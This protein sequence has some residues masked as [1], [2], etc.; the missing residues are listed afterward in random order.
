MKH[1]TN[2][3][4]ILVMLPAGVF[5]MIQE[6]TLEEYSELERLRTDVEDDVRFEFERRCPA[7]AA[8]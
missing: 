4:D 7:Q 1:T 5:E 2:P 3:S 8:V 6:E